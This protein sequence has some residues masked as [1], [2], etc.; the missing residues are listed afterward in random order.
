MEK[1]PAQRDNRRLVKFGTP[2]D[3]AE[4]GTFAVAVCR[5]FEPGTVELFNV[6]GL[7]RGDQQVDLFAYFL[8]IVSGEVIKVD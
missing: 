5:L 6:C 2:G 4:N 7:P 3:R 1:I 8:R